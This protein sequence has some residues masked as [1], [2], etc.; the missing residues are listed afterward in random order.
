M[1]SF[2]EPSQLPGAM[3]TTLDAVMDWYHSDGWGMGGIVRTTPLV[4]Q[5]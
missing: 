1:L 2:T 3:A 5:V 4:E